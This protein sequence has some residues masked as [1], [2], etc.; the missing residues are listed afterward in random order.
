VTAIEPR[1]SGA[2]TEAI[3]RALPMTQ[4]DAVRLL[5]SCQVDRL[6]KQ[7]IVER[8]VDMNPRYGPES[9]RG[10]RPMCGWLMAGDSI[11]TKS[12]KAPSKELL[13][14]YARRLRNAGWTVVEPPQ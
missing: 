9:G 11:Y 10:V 4:R 14:A 1:N 13:M 6:I 3:L 5:G 8:Y 12:T 7:G 2:R